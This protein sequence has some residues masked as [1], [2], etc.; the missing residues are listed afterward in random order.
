MKYFYIATG[1]LFALMSNAFAVPSNQIDLPMLVCPNVNQLQVD[2]MNGTA[3]APGGWSGQSAIPLN[4][5]D[6]W[7]NIINS[8]NAQDHGDAHEAECQY[9][10]DVAG[11][12]IDIYKNPIPA[13]YKLYDVQDGVEVLSNCWIEQ[14]QINSGENKDCYWYKNPVFSKK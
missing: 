3:T 5:K 8:I 2:I 1:A 10:T 7:Q 9:F 6:D 4:H 11:N 14:A 13:N 12:M